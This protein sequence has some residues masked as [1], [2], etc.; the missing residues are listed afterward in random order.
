ME[1]R[2]VVITGATG[3]VGEATAHA[4]AADG[5]RVIACGRDRSRLAALYQTGLVTERLALDDT[6]EWLRVLRGADAV[7]H[8]AA[9][10]ADWGRR[11]DF[12]RDNVEGTASLLT[13][14]RRVGVPRLV[15]V[16]TA[17]VYFTG[18]PRMNLVE[19]DALDH[20]PMAYPASKR[21]AE[22]RVMAAHA[23]GDV[24]AVVLRPR[25]VIGRGDRHIVPRLLTALA[26]G[27]LPRL[28]QSP[29]ST[30]L[31][32]IGNLV[33]AIQ[34][35]LHVSS[36]ALGGV[37]HVADPAPVSLWPSLDALADRAGVPRA[38]RRV[39]RLLVRALAAFSERTAREAPLLT[40]YG[41]ALLTT[42]MTLDCSAARRALGYAPPFTTADGLAE[43][44]A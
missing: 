27:R 17:S 42:T 10:A 31:T 36:E 6:P 28:D 44:V 2:T 26:A 38:T 16:S 35:A 41:A 21:E 43:A 22:R 4:L 40:R 34:C 12:W 24:E 15:H 37:Y 13:A 29:V 8:C 33:H 19:A 14:M 9:R 18:A 39:P 30:H 5:W 3:F 1:R 32:T 11:A 25:G 20:P 23:A 7:V